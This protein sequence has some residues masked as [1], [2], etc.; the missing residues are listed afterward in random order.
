MGR[1]RRDHH[2]RGCA[3]PRSRREPRRRDTV[4]DARA[5]AGDADAVR[6]GGGIR[7]G[8]VRGGAARRRWPAPRTAG[9]PAVRRAAAR[10]R[11]RPPGGDRN[12][13]SGL[14]GLVARRRSG[15]RLR[16]GAPGTV[17]R[18]GTHRGILREPGPDRGGPAR[19]GRRRS[20]PGGRPLR[21]VV[22][23]AGRAFRLPRL[24]GPARCAQRVLGVD[25][26]PAPGRAAQ[27]P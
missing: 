15:A 9:A 17:Y 25:V 22:S 8:A 4:R 14:A 21:P 13:G 10:W 24:P 1:C 2:G 5:A 12:P 27:R 23:R 6:L 11:R 19:P 18:R 3:A 7:R 20:R 16:P 26:R